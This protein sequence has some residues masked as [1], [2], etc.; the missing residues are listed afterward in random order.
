MMNKN[1]TLIIGT[2]GS[3]L[4][5]AQTNLVADALKKIDPSLTIEIKIIV[6][7]GDIDQSPIPAGAVGKSWFT[8][9]IDQ[10]IARGDIDL[11][12]HSLKDL[13]PNI[14]APLVVVAVLPRGDAA[15]VLVS[16][17]GVALNDL[18]ERAVVGTDS[19]RRK[20]FLLAARPDLVIKSIRGNVD[21]RLKKLAAEDYD[22]IVIAAAGLERLCLEHHATERLDPK[23]FIPAPGQ[24]I[25]AVEVKNGRTDIL[26]MI[27]SIAHAPTAIAAEIE[28]SFSAA[29]GGGCKLPVGCYAEIDG[30]RVNIYAA[31]GNEAGD[32]IVRKFEHG[33]AAD[34]KNLAQALAKKF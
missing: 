27:N 26:E 3:A 1:N 12:V 7:K 8:A 6:T 29:V 11:A 23:I 31:I 18:K 21:T 14:S 17:N 25:L 5:L 34:G 15:D 2:R 10:A 22:A 9:E 16:K 19:V 13:P 30:E 28:R 4:A 24:A 33:A 20:M 32:H